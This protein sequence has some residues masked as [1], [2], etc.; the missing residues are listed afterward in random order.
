MASGQ[1]VASP[2]DWRLR[3]LELQQ[4]ALELV[5]G[6]LPPPPTTVHADL[7]H[8]ATVP[9]GT[10]VRVRTYRVR[11]DA[12]HALVLR[13]L[14]PRGDGPFPV[15]LYGDS[16]WAYASDAVRERFLAAGYAWA[17]FNRVEI[18]SDPAP[19]TGLPQCCD[20][21]RGFAGGAIAAW[22]WGFQRAVDALLQCPELDPQGLAVL[23]HSR[24]GKAALLAGA[25]D[26][27]IALTSA[28]N[29]GA[30]G[31]GS[32]HCLGEGAETLAD[33]VDGFGHWLSPELT[34]FKGREDELPFDQHFLKALIAPRYLLTTE[35]L[36]DLWANPSGSWASHQAAQQAYDFLDASSRIAIAFR[37]GAHAHAAA[38]WH[39]LLLHMNAAF[40]A[41][42][43]P[44]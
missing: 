22:A 21:L 6:P 7:L 38:D 25:L 20:A 29:S 5:Y 37:R 23:G 30:G 1:P 12:G 19:G 42:A 8:E 44:V 9:D 14:L 2:A 35:S 16:C 13:V 10:G 31:A 3:R 4:L 17:E 32:F 39:T 36:D 33:I 40:K 43:L 18:M 24:G 11:A 28:N 41:E 15:L 26:E 27:R 34:R